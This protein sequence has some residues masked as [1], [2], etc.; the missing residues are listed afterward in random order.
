MEEVK[1]D[2]TVQD[3]QGTEVAPIEPSQFDFDEYAAYEAE[4]LPK[5]KAFTEAD[6]GLL[7]YRRVRANGVFY[8][9]CRDYKESLALQL[10]ALKMSLNYKADIPN[11]LE[12]WYGIG[13]IASCFGSTYLWLPGAAPEVKAKFSSAQEIVDAYKAGNYDPIAETKEGK[14][15][16]EM[17]D[18]FVDQTKGKLPISFSDLQSPLNMLTY[19]LPVTAVFED[20]Y[21]DPDTLKEAASICTDLLIDFLKEQE[22]RLGD[23]LARPGHGFASSRAFKGVGLSDDISIMLGEDDYVDLFQDLDQKIGDEYGGF[24][25][26]SCGVWSK[27]IHMVKSYKNITCADGAFTIETDP[28]P[29]NPDDFADEFAGSGI[30]LN[31]RGVGDEEHSYDCFRRLWRPKQKLI[32][33]TYCKSPEE[34]ARLYDRLHAM[35]AETV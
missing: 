1:F 32:C 26:H 19:L 17:I 13:Y 3:S 16:L 24:V 31:A 18:Y 8:D 15:N 22:K 33:V 7:V 30:I 34:Q 11:F 23:T 28:K 5:I 14:Y 12:P 2:T 21:D 4:R 27:K 10:G 35:E 25:Y 29:N 20:V 9:K 6:Q